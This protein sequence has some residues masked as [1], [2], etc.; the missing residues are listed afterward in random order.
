M[1]WFQGT[2]FLPDTE[3]VPS[4]IAF[5]GS[6]YFYFYAYGFSF[7]PHFGRYDGS[8]DSW[9]ELTNPGETFGSN[10]HGSTYHDGKV[11]VFAANEVA[12]DLLAT[13]IYDVGG[14]SW[15]RGTDTPAS[16]TAAEGRPQAF[17][18]TIDDLAYVIGGT[19]FSGF[20]DNAHRLDIYDFALDSWT[21]GA[22]LPGNGATA[23]GGAVLDGKIHVVG[24]ED[25]ITAD[26]YHNHFSYDPGTDTWTTHADLPD[27]PDLAERPSLAQ[28][29]STGST[30]LFI[31]RDPEFGNISTWTWDP[32]G[33]TWSEDEQASSSGLNL[34]TEAGPI[35]KVGSRIIACGD[36]VLYAVS[37]LVGYWDG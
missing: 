23:P 13:R 1:E 10:V 30:I 12:G 36:F 24:G 3:S 4:Q 21:V 34:P 18:A 16:S 2:S 11:Y 37:N 15:S 25:R 26:F 9:T 17:A 19:T 32:G 29:Y 20:A 33:D 14:D 31:T 6:T 7:E 8:A 28:V 5:D 27:V 35:F 22:D